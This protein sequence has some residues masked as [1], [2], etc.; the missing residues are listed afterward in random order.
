MTQSKKNVDI[1]FSSLQP[2]EHIFWNMTLDK[3]RLKSFVSWFLKNHGEKKTIQLL[4]QLK[5]LGFGYATQAGISLGIEDLKIPPN[6]NKLLGEAQI[7]ISN[8]LISYRKGE[9]TGIEKMQQFIE[10]WNETNETLKQEV[11]RYFEKTDILNPVYMMAFSGAR[12][13]LSQVRQLVGMRGLMSDPQGKIIDYP[14]QSNFREGLTLTEYL[15]STYGAR[16]GI[17]DTALRTATAGYLTRRLVD[18]AQH[19]IVSTFD[20][21]TRRGIFLF[22]MKEG[23]KTLY[24]FANRLIGRVL[25]QDIHLSIEGAEDLRNPSIIAFRNQ[26]VNTELAATIAK[27]TKKAL[28]R[29]PLTCETRKLVCQL[30]YGW[31]LATSRLVSI[32]EAV[33]VIAGQSIGEP[34]TQLTMRTFHTGGVF[35][36]GITEQINAPFSGLVEYA[37]PISGTC[38]R[39]PQGFLAFLTKTNGTLFLK[40]FEKE[41]FIE[42]L[43]GPQGA[44]PPCDSFDF[45]QPQKNLSTSMNAYKIPPFTILFARHGE[46]IEKSKLLAQI[47]ALPTGQKATQTIEQTVYSSL[48]GE[49]YYSQI[50]LLE[51]I[52]EK[53]GERISK[54][55]DWSKVW[56]LSA[57]ISPDTVI[58]EYLPNCGDFVSK[59]SIVNEIQWS[60]N[61]SRS[62]YIN[63]NSSNVQNFTKNLEYSEKLQSLFKTLP[64]SFLPKN[65]LKYRLP[66][67]FSKIYNF[68]FETTQG[69]K[70]TSLVSI[71]KFPLRGS[72][73]GGQAPSA[74]LQPLVARWGHPRPS[75]R[76]GG[77]HP[78]GG[79]T[80]G[81][82]DPMLA[83][84]PELTSFVQWAKE[85]SDIRSNFKIC[86]KYRI[87]QKFLSNNKNSTNFNQ[88]LK[89]FFSKQNYEQMFFDR[90]L[91]KLQTCFVYPYQAN[92]R[93]HFMKMIAQT[94][95]FLP[96]VRP[97]V[98]TSCLNLKVLKRQNKKKKNKNILNLVQKQKNI[99]VRKLN[100]NKKFKI[101]GGNKTNFFHPLI[102]TNLVP[103]S[104]TLNSKTLKSFFKRKAR[105]SDFRFEKSILYPYFSK[106][107]KKFVNNFNFLEQQNSDVWLYKKCVKVKQAESSR[108][109]NTKQKLVLQHFKIQKLE[110][111]K[112]NKVVLKNTTNLKLEQLSIKTP[113]LFLNPQ[114]IRYQKF[115][116]LISVSIDSNQTDQLFSFLPLASSALLGGEAPSASTSPKPLQGDMSMHNSKNH[117]SS[118]SSEFLEISSLKESI[119]NTK[120]KNTNF[121]NV[122]N[123]ENTDFWNPSSTQGFYWFPKFSQTMTNGIFL[124]SSPIIAKKT[125]QRKLLKLKTKSAKSALK[126]TKKH[127]QFLNLAQ[128]QIHK[129]SK[130]TKHRSLKIL[131]KKQF[132]KFLKNRNKYFVI[133]TPVFFAFNLNKINLDSQNLINKMSFNKMRI[134]LNSFNKIFL[135]KNTQQTM[136]NLKNLHFNQFFSSFNQFH[137][138]EHKVFQ[139]GGKAP[140]AIK[141]RLL[142]QK[143]IRQTFDFKYLSIKKS[144]AFSSKKLEKKKFTKL[145]ETKKFQFSKKDFKN[146]NNLIV[147]FSDFKKLSVPFQEIQ[148]LPQENYSVNIL[149]SHQKGLL[150]EDDPTSAGG[151]GGGFVR[152]ATLP[153]PATKGCGGGFTPSESA[154]GA[155]ETF[156]ASSATGTLE[157]VDFGSGL[158]ASAYYK[159][160]NFSLNKSQFIFNSNHKNFA[161]T[162]KNSKIYLTN[163]QGL[164]KEFVI[165]YDGLLKLQNS[166]FLNT[167]G[168]KNLKLTKSYSFKNIKFFLFQKK[169]RINLN[170][171]EP[172]ARANEKNGGQSSHPNSNFLMKF[173][174]DLK[175]KFLN[176]ILKK[177]SLKQ[178]LLFNNEKQKHSDKNK[179]NDWFCVKFQNYTNFFSFLPLLKTSPNFEL[180]NFENLEIVKNFY[181]KIYSEK[182][183]QIKSLPLN[184]IL[185][186]GW[187]YKTINLS[188]LGN[189]HKTMIPAGNILLDDLCFEQQKIFVERIPLSGIHSTNLRNITFKNQNSSSSFNVSSKIYNPK[190][191]FFNAKKEKNETLQFLALSEQSSLGLPETQSVPTGRRPPVA[192]GLRPLRKL[193]E[194]ALP[195][196]QAGDQRSPASLQP[197]VAEG[198][199]RGAKPPSPRGRLPAG[200]QSV[201]GDL[202][203]RALWG[204]NECFVRCFPVFTH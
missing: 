103:F 46:F 62:S 163:S 139:R 121:I 25:A 3:G 33:G 56:V 166:K 149:I 50:D 89:S 12:G 57:K 114:K 130:L 75:F 80:S 184:I 186:P 109:Q 74:S 148:W 142:D 38:I 146:S 69:F 135:K 188:N 87:Q 171:F 7:F 90:S 76:L 180:R 65:E 116:Y 160:K 162:K 126:Y 182:I 47:S 153:G 125:F 172:L 112:L 107:S 191:R 117:L 204:Y 92:F 154:V 71:R 5:K 91:K 37:E 54:A 9:I 141:D 177:K 72:G 158:S 189:M 102:L 138:Q 96:M 63:W 23:N 181:K 34:G 88:T 8:S 77:S 16:K 113:I 152:G 198:A 99:L 86:S 199:S 95:I 128:S 44:K 59:N 168:N 173:Q 196:P 28:V 178:N 145:D 101:S 129:K 144:F 51:D 22:D 36:G 39:T 155:T 61:L 123:L 97:G 60:T 151:A 143:I 120:V 98:L 195:P 140:S 68:A 21:K 14:I 157:A 10:T 147:K 136:L 175:V 110:K 111:K 174:F 6:K 26:E 78:M 35:S 1:D 52:D 17:V 197:E 49:V 108:L 30:C 53:Y 201:P 118:Q 156:E 127:I 24:S 137:W 200:T 193:C 73:G 43:Q 48:E 133:L 159:L 20:C 131:K 203:H 64:N 124:V 185:K 27:F 29:S 19:V 15:I 93:Y 79:T 85:I 190:C 194:G 192:R 2:N 169:F 202:H 58:S 170:A 94:R 165:N 167:F 41:S 84:R 18:V 179:F 40:K 105:M 55:E 66:I 4:E 104:S 67:N 70:Q 106:N 187:I 82:T 183:L 150:E 115:G 176:Y 45:K 122:V 11:V 13:N 81:L 161:Q 132:S 119:K 42:G 31:S 83:K 100:M 134:Y 164:K 32:G